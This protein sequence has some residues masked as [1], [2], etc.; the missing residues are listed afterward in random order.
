MKPW[1][2]SVG[3]ENRF[4]SDLGENGKSKRKF[5]CCFVVFILLSP[6]H[7]FEEIVSAIVFTLLI[8][9]SIF[10]S[11]DSEFNIL[12]LFINQKTSSPMWIYISSLFSF[13]VRKFVVSDTIA[14]LS[15]KRGAH[16]PIFTHERK[17]AL[18][19]QNT[20][21]VHH[22]KII[23]SMSDGSDS[24][25]FNGFLSCRVSILRSHDFKDSKHEGISQIPGKSFLQSF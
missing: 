7:T 5:R 20:K 17:L 9:K 1:N 21:L 16:F 6:H 12:N 22:T 4:E 18:P 25:R 13:T 11:S 24:L 10:L 23:Y 14:Q 19:N 8:W 2:A 3:Y 15:E